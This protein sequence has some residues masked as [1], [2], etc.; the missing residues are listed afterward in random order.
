LSVIDKDEV[1][2]ELE[3]AVRRAIGDTAAGAFEDGV[4]AV[5]K[6]LEQL[7]RYDTRPALL[8]ERV[9]LNAAGQVE[10]KLKTPWR[11][12]STHLVMSPLAFMRRLAA[13]ATQPR[14]RQPMT[15]SQPSIPA[16]GCPDWV[17]AGRPIRRT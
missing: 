9:Q 17:A 3:S 15:A 12:G 10:L 2:S 13:P 14:L 8:G 7:C 6:R 5:A 1:G 4:R 16:I 11:D